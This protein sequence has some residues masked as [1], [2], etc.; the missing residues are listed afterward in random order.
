MERRYA[1]IITCTLLF[2]ASGTMLANNDEHQGAPNGD[3]HGSQ[4][5]TYYIPAI[6]SGLRW[7]SKV[8]SPLAEG[9]IFGLCAYYGA[10]QFNCNA[11]ACTSY[12]MGTGALWTLG[13]GTYQYRNPN[14]A[15]P[16]TLHAPYQAIQMAYNNLKTAQK[17]S[18]DQNEE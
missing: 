15:V 2:A 6:R 17:S 10:K 11:S 4:I 8:V 16:T 12:A 7:C 5:S 18:N 1:G 3:K 13:S 14:T 9:A